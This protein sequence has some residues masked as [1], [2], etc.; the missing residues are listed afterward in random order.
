[1]IVLGGLINHDNQELVSKVPILG[2]IPILGRLFQSTSKRQIKR[3]L[4]VF[5]KPKIL[6]TDSDLSQL[7]T[8]KYNYFKASK[9]LEPL[10]P[11]KKK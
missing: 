3:S 7:T 1:M 10:S 9:Y 2:S 4:M 5:L 6:L 8:S 11:N